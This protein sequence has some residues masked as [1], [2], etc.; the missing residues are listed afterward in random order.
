MA[1]HEMTRGLAHVDA[2]VTVS[3]MAKDPF[4]F[5]VKGVHGHPSERDAFLEFT[6]VGRELHVLPCPSLRALLSRSDAV[7]RRESEV[8]MTRCVLGALQAVWRYIGF[9]KIGHWIAAG[10][11]KQE[12]VL[13]IGDPVSAEPHAHAAAQ[14]LGVQ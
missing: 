7:P 13:A 12:Y 5:F 2:M 10:L 1:N 8:R 9:G 11:E 6:R 14:R 3:G 4:V